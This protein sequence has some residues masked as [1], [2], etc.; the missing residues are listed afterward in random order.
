MRAIIRT[1]RG[2]T[3]IEVLVTVIIL[4]VGL[5]GI[6]GLQSRLQTSEMEAYQR[7]Q[8]LILLND[9]ANRIASNRNDAASYSANYGPAS[10]LGVG[11]TCPDNTGSRR[12]RD[13]SEWCAALQGAA[14]TV[15]GGNVGAMLGGRGCVE[16][17]GSGQYL[18]T[19]AWQGLAP[20]TAPAAGTACGANSYDGPAG[21]T[22]SDDRCRRV[23][24]TIVRVAAL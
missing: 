19:V 13:A 12:Q 16:S 5:L 7:A 6:A 22:C 20:I 21:S 14:E 17:L 24:T 15:G 9:M 18:V 23:V 8:A 4:S 1:Q 11:M 10:P 2:V 3:L